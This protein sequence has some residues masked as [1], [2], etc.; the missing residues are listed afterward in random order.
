MHK[1]LFFVKVR[2]SMCSLMSERQD[3]ILKP[4]ELER[5]RNFCN[6]P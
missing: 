6:K 2:M 5:V 4:V 3:F 1:K